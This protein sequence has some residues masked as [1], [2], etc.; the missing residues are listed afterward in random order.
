MM[1]MKAGDFVDEKVVEER[2]VEHR[3]WYVRTELV[4]EIDGK[5][6]R[7]SYDKGATESQETEWDKEIEL[8][9][10]HQVEKTVKVWEP[11]KGD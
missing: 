11:V 6:W 1:T 8:T 4:V 9:E 7:G 3:R 5:F 10:V 2:L